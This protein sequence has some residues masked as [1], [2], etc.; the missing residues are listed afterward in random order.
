MAM[1]RLPRQLNLLVLVSL[2]SSTASAV[3]SSLLFA[4]QNSCKAEG[5][6]TCGSPFPRNFCCPTGT[7]CLSLAGDTTVLCC[8]EGSTC[9]RIESI[10]CNLDALDP[11]DN[12]DAPVKTTVLD[13]ALEKCNDGTCC[14]F[15]YSCLGDGR[16]EKNEDQSEAPKADEPTTTTT[17]A[18][19]E[20]TADPTTTD[21]DS[22]TETDPPKASATGDNSESDNSEEDNGP[23]TASIV[24]GVVGGCAIL[25]IVAVALLVLVRRRAKQAPMTE[26]SQQKRDRTK[27]NGF[28]NIIS[29]PILQ[30]DQYRADFILRPPTTTSTTQEPRWPDRQASTR[31]RQR[32]RVSIPNPFNSPNPSV[33]DSASRASTMTYDDDN[34][35][36]GQVTSGARLPPIR[37]MKASSRH[38]RP[39]DAMNRQPSAESINVFADPGTVDRS[40]QRQTTFTDLMDEADLRGVGRDRPFVQVPGTT[41]R[42]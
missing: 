11:E 23:D 14:P 26:K 41:P 40:H 5:F 13:V 9:N 20:P 16:C 24:G 25:L 31:G 8:P 37:S 42:I 15:G 1:A 21:T 4:R 18:P 3:P 36:T 33:A 19:A 28:S 39:S 6:E 10:T 12:P 7:Q 30:P 34:V 29:D 17:K 32:P 2:L 35:R 22:S 38:L 27:S